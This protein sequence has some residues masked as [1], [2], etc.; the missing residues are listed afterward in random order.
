MSEFANTGAAAIRSKA[1]DF[2]NRVVNQVRNEA[3]LNLSGKVLNVD[4]G[5]L[6]TSVTGS[7]K[8]AASGNTVTGSV[9][10]N[11][12]YGVMWEETGH[13]AFE[14]VPRVA[15]AL[16]IRVGTAIGYRRKTREIFA[17]GGIFIYRK[18]ARIPAA[19]PR[20]FIKPA[21]DA[22]M[23]F[24]EQLHAEYYG[25]VFKKGK[26]GIVIKVRGDDGR[27]ETKTIPWS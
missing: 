26:G 16:K 22:A 7:A 27:I 19:A 6:R 2:M 17:K 10:T 3:V 18:R 23:G 25:S 12:W 13:K 4:T 14:V 20:P 21:F 24:I 11:V 8:V 5:R 1:I 9:G 15:K